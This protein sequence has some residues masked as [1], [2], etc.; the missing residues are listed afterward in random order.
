MSPILWGQPATFFDRSKGEIRRWLWEFGDGSASHNQSPDH[1]YPLPGSYDTLLTVTDRCGLLANVGSGIEVTAEMPAPNAVIEGRAPGEDIDVTTRHGWFVFWTPVSAPRG[2]IEYTVQ[3]LTSSNGEWQEVARTEETVWEEA[4]TFD[5]R[6]LVGYRVRAEVAGI[7]TGQWA[8]SDGVLVWQGPAIERAV[9]RGTVSQAQGITASRNIVVRVEGVSAEIQQ[10]RLSEESSFVGAEWI[11]LGGLVEIPFELAEGPDGVRALYIQGADGTRTETPPVTALILLDSSGPDADGLVLEDMDRRVSGVTDS[12]TVRARLPWTGGARWVAWGEGSQCAPGRWQPLDD[13][14]LT[15]TFEDD[16]EGMK[17]VCVWLQDLAGNITGPAQSSIAYYLD[18]PS[19]GS[20]RVTDMR[21]GT[22]GY[23]TNSSVLVELPVADLYGEPTDMRIWEDDDPEPDTWQKFPGFEIPY[24]LI[25]TTEGRHAL[26]VRLRDALHRQG[27]AVSDQFIID[28][29]APRIP[30]AG[31]WDTRID[32]SGG[33]LTLL[34]LVDEANPA[35]V[36]LLYDGLPT[37]AHL[38]D[39]GLDGDWSAGDGIYSINIALPSGMIP[40]RLLFSLR[41][42]DLAGH[43]SDVWPALTI[44]G[45]PVAG[46]AD[47]PAAQG[48]WQALAAVR[49]AL[50]AAQTA[51]W[52]AAPA[53]ATIM[54]AGTWYSGIDALRG[55]NLT[56]LAYAPS[57]ERVQLFYAGQPTGAFLAD[58]GLSNDFA[59]GD[60]FWA[61]TI[62]SVPAGLPPGQ[63]LWELAAED[64]SGTAGDLFPYLTIHGANQPP[65]AVITSPAAGCVTNPVTLTGVGLDADG[66]DVRLIWYADG[67]YLG[68]GAARQVDLATGAHTI[69]LIAVDDA[70]ASDTAHIE[71]GVDIVSPVANLTVSELRRGEPLIIEALCAVSGGFPPFSFTWSFDGAPAVEGGNSVEYS[72]TGTGTHTIAVEARD[73]CGRIARA[74]VLDLVA[75][76]LPPDMTILSPTGDLAF[77]DRQPVVLIGEGTDPEDGSLPVTALH[78]ALAGDPLG[79][80]REIPLQPLP[81]GDHRVTLRGSDSA[82]TTGEADAQLSITHETPISSCRLTWDGTR[83]SYAI[84]VRDAWAGEQIRWL[85][86]RN[87]GTPYEQILTLTQDV[88]ELTVAQSFPY[89]LAAGEHIWGQISFR[90]VLH[91]EFTSECEAELVIP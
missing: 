19:A 85:W 65:R 33:Q 80:G 66:G 43:R 77:T 5:P 61:L 82:G 76:N 67:G 59:A 36:E 74:E 63:L 24:T 84:A 46:L 13:G 45:A 27:A 73:G 15:Y 70:G 28:A 3:R 56:L 71:L 8:N 25:H 62:E 83:A 34:A 42:S 48:P 37:G 50:T 91:P 88:A 81:P 31:Y 39:N 11:P 58:D 64:A 60:K 22:A 7:A 72:F 86:R 44:H 9:L 10:I 1:I 21:Y 30:V 57:A 68:E 53:P 41:A 35:E 51:M 14:P 2:R 78:W 90:S 38:M 47:A 12:R 40:L 79:M 89:S 29:T 18:G 87:G 23:A 26:H 17:T 20:L 55:G 69:T 32:A 16:S 75:G 54:V 52:R 4:E 6:T 49:D